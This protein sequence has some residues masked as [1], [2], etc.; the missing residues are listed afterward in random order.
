MVRIGLLFGR[1]VLLASVFVLPCFAQTPTPTPSPT[2]RVKAGSTTHQPE[3]N[4]FKDIAGDQ[5]AIWTSPFHIQHSDWKWLAPFV[6][7]TAALIATD[8][9]TSSWVGT[10]G[11]LPKISRDVSLFGGVYATVG[12]AGGMWAFGAMSHN[13]HLR[14][15]GRLATEALADTEVLVEA[16]KFAFGRQRPNEAHNEVLFFR[17]GRSFFSGHSAASWSVATVVA[18]EYHDH[19]LAVWGAYGLAAAVSLSRYTGR[20]HFLSDVFVGAGIGYGIGRYVCHKHASY[21]EGD[22]S[23]TVSR[24]WR[25]APYLDAKTATRGGSFVWKF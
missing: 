1:S 15:T 5:K 2:P 19:P 3:S 17:N 11:S 22:D 21:A 16:S 10:R 24:R 25:I 4:I 20:N 12:I 18:C 9:Q 14:E 6:G 23:S 8:E 7:G 13:D